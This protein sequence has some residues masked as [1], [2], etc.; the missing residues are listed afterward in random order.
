[1]YF[2]FFEI[3]DDEVPKREAEYGINFGALLCAFKDDTWNDG[4]RA[5]SLD[6]YM[7]CLWKWSWW[8][9]GVYLY[10]SK[11][12]DTCLQLL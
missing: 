3:V 1:M 6:L 4:R 2:A 5:N 11:A 7:T 10:D 8:R 12:R 9:P